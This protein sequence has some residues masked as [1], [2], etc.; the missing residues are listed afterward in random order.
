MLNIEDYDQWAEVC[1]DDEL[2]FDLY[3]LGVRPG[4]EQFKDLLG[5]PGKAKPSNSKNSL[6]LV[7]AT[8]LT[9]GVAY[10]V[11]KLIKFVG[12]KIKSKFNKQIDEES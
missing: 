1:D 12:K 4:T 6:I 9:L 11:V 5:E 7:A 2:I 10:G 3:N 8:V